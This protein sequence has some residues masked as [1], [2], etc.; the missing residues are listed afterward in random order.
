[1]ADIKPSK[2]RE[3]A[4]IYGTA[5]G[6]DDLM[7]TLRKGLPMAVFDDVRE[8]LDIPAAN[9]ASILSIPTR[10]L[11]R[12][13]SSGRLDHLESERLHRIARL[14]DRAADVLGDESRARTWML[15]PA[16]ALGGHTPLD[17]AGSEFGAVEVFNLLGRLEHGVYP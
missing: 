2:V 17:Y 1:M 14:L 11:T 3:V 4:P 10:T 12:R 15:S 5:T 13:R 9:L 7:E 6:L 16:T 8:R